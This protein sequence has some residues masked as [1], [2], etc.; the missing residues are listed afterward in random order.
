[1][2]HNKLRHIGVSYNYSNLTPF[3]FPFFFFLGGGG[4]E[5][6]GGGRV[7]LILCG[8]F[9]PS[10][11]AQQPQVQRYLFVAVSPVFLCP[12]SGMAVSVWDFNML[13]DVVACHCTRRLYGHRKRS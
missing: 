12:N 13:I 9:R 11:P 5:G 1:M 4:V 3:P 6:G 2:V 10:Y 7:L 8:E